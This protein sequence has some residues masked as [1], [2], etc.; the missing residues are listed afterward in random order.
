MSRYAD[1]NDKTKKWTT[2][3]LAAIRPDA[4]NEILREIGGLAGEVRVSGNMAISV[5]FRFA[6]KWE[7]V[8]ADRKLTI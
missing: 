3:A 4:Q 6:F 1:P 8:A 7:G 2:K 5:N